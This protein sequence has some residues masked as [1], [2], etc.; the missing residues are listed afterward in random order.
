M[1]CCQIP[2]PAAPVFPPT[3]IPDAERF[4]KY[5]GGATLVDIGAI[6]PLTVL[7]SALHLEMKLWNTEEPL[8]HPPYRI[9][10][11][12]HNSWLAM[13]ARGRNT[14][15]QAE[16]GIIFAG[17]NPGS[18]APKQ[19]V[20]T[21][22]DGWLLTTILGLRTQGMQPV[23][24]ADLPPA[25]RQPSTL[26]TVGRCQKLLNVFLKH[27]LCWH[28]AGRWVGYPQFVLYAPPRSPDLPQYLCALHAPIDRFVLQALT[29]LPLGLGRRGKNLLKNNGDVKQSSDG[30]FRPWSQL[31]C[32]RT[33]YG[34]QLMLRR[35]AMHTWP[36]GCACGG[37]SNI[38]PLVHVCG[39][40]NGKS[41]AAAAKKLTQDCADW[42]EKTF[43]P[44]HPC[45]NDNIDWI[46]AACELKDEVIEETLEKI[47]ANTA[48]SGGGGSAPAALRTNPSSCESSGEDQ[49][50]FPSSGCPQCALGNAILKEH[51]NRFIPGAVPAVLPPVGAAVKVQHKNHHR[52]R[53]PG[54]YGWVW[55]YHVNLKTVRVDLYSEQ[56]SQAAAVNRYTTFCAPRVNPPFP[57]YPPFPFG[58]IGNQSRSI[59]KSTQSG[60]NAE[61]AD[62][63]NIA[64]E[65][66]DIMQQIFTL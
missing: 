31:N 5:A 15:S 36:V 1:P 50:V 26:S 14:F 61:P 37:A 24:E 63:P 10:D 16:K 55:Q 57:G 56:G 34:L 6:A 25:P 2:N 49:P 35:I 19:C 52:I 3:L 43:G 11:A 29:A 41:P 45:Q 59:H 65:A 20:L 40:P 13:R 53:C 27:E 64:K 58:I 39:S 21:A 44:K 60:A 33:Y 62:F 23:R 17:L 46:K 22:Y 32:L 12:E 9:N 38:S 4:S 30:N 66:V 48:D 8:P 28:V 51:R 54:A 7:T 18:P 42:F 47:G